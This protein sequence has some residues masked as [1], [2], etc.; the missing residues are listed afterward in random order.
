MANLLRLIAFGRNV[1][2]TKSERGVK[3]KK[4][5]LKGYSEKYRHKSNVTEGAAWQAEPLT[6]V[7]AQL[8]VERVELVLDILWTGAVLAGAEVQKD[9]DLEKTAQRRERTVRK[10]VEI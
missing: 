4:K 10:K 6:T 8:I 9:I 3:K 2:N 1:K 5:I 7:Q